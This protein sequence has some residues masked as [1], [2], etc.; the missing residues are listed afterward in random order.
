MKMRV[1]SLRALSVLTF[2]IFSF[3]SMA[4]MPT[5][6]T[7]GQ[8]MNAG[9]IYGKIVDG[10]NKPIEAASVQ[11]TQ[12]KMDTVT[13]HKRDFVVAAM[14]TDKKGEFSIDKL[15][16]FGSFQLLVSAIGF[17][18]LDQKVSFNLKMNG[19]DMSQM[20]NAVDKDL[21]NLKL[22]EDAKQLEGVV[23][24]ANKGLLQMNIDRKVFNVDKSLTSVGGTAVDVMKNVPSVNVDIDGNVTLRNAAP[25]IFIDGRPTTL[26]LD[27][28]PA[29][30]IESVEII[31]N[32]SAKF[33]ASGGGSG[34]LNIVLK[35]NRK[36]GYNG[37]LRANV[38][39][40]GSLGGGADV[41]I[42]QGK[43][44]FFANTMFN[45]RKSRSTSTTNRVDQIEDVNAVL[46]QKSNPNS[47]GHFAFVRGGF[48]YLLDNRNTFTL[49]GVIVGGKFGNTDMLNISRDST[50]GSYVSSELGRSNTNGNFSFN[51][52]GGT[53]SYKHNFAKAGKEI[54][55]DANYNSSKNSNSQLVSTQYFDINNVANEF[56]QYLFVETNITNRI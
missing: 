9:H 20:M 39:S 10:N 48:D 4:Q 13:K 15:P 55:A 30:E 54:T 34:I 38:D 6:R 22:K 47:T 56:M 31:T 53:F 45:Q 12:S 33:D 27:Q 35:K 11:L 23:V 25:Q 24:T 37:N 26:T 1:I 2:C 5:A 50:I 19:G 46:N 40:R 14:L 44:N 16:V 52:Y 43:I 3:F 17:A 28:I 7:G 8:N 51:N 21:G 32:P 18:P 49:S 41:N 42:K 29:D 36:A